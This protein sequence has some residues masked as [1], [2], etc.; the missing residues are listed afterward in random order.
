MRICSGPKGNSIAI[1]S[2]E[3]L[4]KQCMARP[5]TSLVRACVDTLGFQLKV[6]LKVELKVDHSNVNCSDKGLM[7][8]MSA[9]NF[10]HGVPLP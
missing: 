7:L 4:F 3:N 9:V 5:G 8:E 1:H 2:G 6:D 10:S